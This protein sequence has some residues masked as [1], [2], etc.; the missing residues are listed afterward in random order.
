MK[1]LETVNLREYAHRVSPSLTLKR[2]DFPDLRADFVARV[3][4]IDDARWL[5]FEMVLDSVAAPE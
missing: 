4:W 1:P 5:P 3:V 2:A